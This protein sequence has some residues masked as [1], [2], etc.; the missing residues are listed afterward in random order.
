MAQEEIHPTTRLLRMGSRLARWPLSIFRKPPKVRMLYLEVT[1]RCNARCITCYTKAGREKPDVLTFEE[2]E[3]VVSQARALGAKVVSLSGSGEPLLYERLFDLIDFIRDLGM[4]VV[5]FT[6]GTVLDEQTAE[7]LIA[8]GV[9]TYVKLYSLDPEVF[10]RMMGRTGVYAWMP[11][12]YTCD[13]AARQVRIPAGLKHMLDAQTRAGVKDLVR[14]E[15]LITRL[16]MPTLGEVARFCKELDLMLHLETLVFT[17]WALENREQI[18]LDRNAYQ[19]LYQELVAI[20]G[21]NYFHEHRAHPCPV[22]RNPVVWTNG[23]VGL[24]S[25]RPAAVGNVRDA[26]LESLFLKARRIKRKEDR[27]VGA[28]SSFGR[29]FRTCPA[30]QYFEKRHQLPCDY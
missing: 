26:S 30:R 23:D 12:A 24:C 6:N 11:H 8:R 1:H 18:A 4:Q 2:K 27:R 10:D 21:E 29:Y 20:L 22:E 25:S 15:T 9:I 3:A 13:G 7:R 14:T 28:H 5:L 16:N 17:G 19:T